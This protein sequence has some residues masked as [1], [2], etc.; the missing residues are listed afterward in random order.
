MTFSNIVSAPDLIT[1][2][3]VKKTL[4]L[5]DLDISAKDD[6]MYVVKDHHDF[7]Q[8]LAEQTSLRNIQLCADAEAA[9][10]CIDYAQTLVLYG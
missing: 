2:A 9:W 7:H 6:A 5:H 10:G 3:L 8:A 1:P 4:T